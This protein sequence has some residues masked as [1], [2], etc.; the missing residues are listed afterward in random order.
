MGWVFKKGNGDGTL[1]FHEEVLGKGGG[2]GALHNGISGGKT[3]VHTTL[4]YL[5]VLEQVAMLVQLL[6]AGLQGF[7]WRT[8]N[9][10]LFQLHFD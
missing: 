10:A 3:F 8:D 4:A 1:W 2:K 9:R 5:D 7:L 6:R